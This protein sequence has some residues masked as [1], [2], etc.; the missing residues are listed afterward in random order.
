MMGDNG[1]DFRRVRD[2]L[3]HVPLVLE[4]QNGRAPLVLHALRVEDAPGGVHGV[5]PPNY[6]PRHR[7]GQVFQR[8]LHAVLLRHARLHH[9]EL[10]LAHR[11]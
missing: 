2:E 8:R 1:S 6:P 4:E 11:R 7:E 5:P 9:L 3:V 10:Q